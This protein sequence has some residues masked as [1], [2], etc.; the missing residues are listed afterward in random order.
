MDNLFMLMLF[1]S[2]GG[3]GYSGLNTIYGLLK[4]DKRK[5]QANK[6]TAIYCA[7]AFVISFVGV[8][9]TNP[10]PT[11]DAANAT[12]AT[13]DFPVKP[14]QH[15]VKKTTTKKDNETKTKKLK[16]Q[17]EKVLAELKKTNSELAKLEYDGTQTIDVNA[18]KP[19]FSELDLSIKEGA[20]E[21]YGDLDELNR[22]TSAE[23]LLN[24]SLM[25]T[26]KRGD[27][28]SVHPTGWKNKKLGNG[29]LYN[30][31]HLIGFALSG[32]NA[33]WKN[34]ITGTQQLNNPEML[35]F[36][37][38]V[39]TYLKKSKKDYV[40]Y[41]VTPI[42]REKELLARGVH[43]MAQSINSDK[44]SFNV[45]IFNIQNDVTLNYADGSS[46]TKEDIQKEK[47]KAAK[48][49][50][51][52][53]IAAE[54]DKA[55]EERLATEKQRQEAEKA[56]Q[57]RIAA[58]KDKVEEERLSAEKQRQE[59]E[60][61]EQERIVAEKAEQERLAAQQ[62]TQ[63]TASQYVDANGN[64]LIKGSKNGIYH[65]PGSTYY[66]RTTNPVRMFKSIEE[67]ESDG[68]RAPNR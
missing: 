42:F 15:A 63:Q 18:G 23:A 50:E 54:K 8:G 34:L 65:V 25:P 58:E 39:K 24:Q 56:E 2:F 68:Y 55:E 20:W 45:Y 48:K 62:Q 43:L 27:I 4:K 61:A 16:K 66:N 33:N 53:R 46:Q 6:K 9:I 14:K 17:H 47:D 59:A 3:L 12:V 11:H 52:E 51:Q 19:T 57:E 31:S 37:M 32:E 7:I 44:I 49:A 29:Y 38:D 13:T 1:V 64:G 21:K 10:Q 22:A 40:R 60:K 28:S 67:A 36:E 41:S 35:R 5:R 26:K 30:R